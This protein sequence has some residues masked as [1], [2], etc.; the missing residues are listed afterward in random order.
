MP[1]RPNMLRYKLI[2]LH[3]AV[4]C[5]EQPSSVEPT[6][7]PGRPPRQAGLILHCPNSN[8]QEGLLRTKMRNFTKERFPRII[9]IYSSLFSWSPRGAHWEKGQEQ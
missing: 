6:L 2:F 1:A 5:G 4:Q 3:P 7:R 8:L 9:F